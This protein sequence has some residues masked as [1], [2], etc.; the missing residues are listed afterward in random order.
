[1]NA[2]CLPQDDFPI[3]GTLPPE[4]FA[5]HE[6]SAMAEAKESLPGVLLYHYFEGDLSLVGEA[7]TTVLDHILQARRIGSRVR[8]Y[9]RE[10][11]LASLGTASPH[12]GDGA[13]ATA[14]GALRDAPGEVR[15]AHGLS[16]AMMAYRA[17]LLVQEDSRLRKF[18]RT[19]GVTRSRPQGPLRTDDLV[20][21]EPGDVEMLYVQRWNGAAWE[22]IA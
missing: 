11:I 21:F 7:G 19:G 3:E 5:A 6:P 17:I 10:Q 22:T 20:F 2:T 18:R 9:S 15:R 12:Y 8:C 14:H 1:M 16:L 4:V 13:Y